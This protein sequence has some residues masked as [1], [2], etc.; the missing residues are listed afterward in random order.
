MSE[1]IEMSPEDREE[2]ERWYTNTRDR[3]WAEE[4]I[5]WTTESY[6]MACI[7]AH[8]SDRMGASV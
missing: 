2:M 8:Q 7:A 3:N 6:A 5:E 4:A 1:V